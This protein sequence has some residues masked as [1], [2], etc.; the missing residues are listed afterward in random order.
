MAYPDLYLVIL[1]YRSG[2][3][4]QVYAVA[5]GAQGPSNFTG[6]IT[7]ERGFIANDP[8]FVPEAT[9]SNADGDSRGRA[10]EEAGRLMA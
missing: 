6:R 9:L 8:H 2:F 4:G 5:R 3:M 1:R 10:K 7:C